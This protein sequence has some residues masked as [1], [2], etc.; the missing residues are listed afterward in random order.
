[1]RP[2]G[3][4]LSNLTG[5]HVGRG[6]LDMQR[7]PGMGTEVFHVRTSEKTAVCKPRRKASGKTKTVDLLI[8]DF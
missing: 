7:D 1:M 4:A 5:V 2:L 3:L 8:L 6:N